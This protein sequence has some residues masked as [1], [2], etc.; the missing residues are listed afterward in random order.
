MPFR[1][2]RLP[3]CVF[4]LSL[5][6]LALTPA[7]PPARAG[8]LLALSPDDL[9]RRA[10]LVVLGTVTSRRPHPL[11]GVP[12]TDVTLAV[13][14][15][16]AGP[17]AREVTFSVLGGNAS[18]LRLEVDGEPGFREG[19]QA[20]VFL[21]RNPA[22]ARTWVLGGVQ[23]KY[24]VRSGRLEA[25]GLP[26]GEFAAR[27]RARL[28]GAPEPLSTALRP[29]ASGAAPAAAAAAA[30]PPAGGPRVL[31]VSPAVVGS[32]ADDT[33]RLTVRGQGFGAA[34]GR[35]R[36]MDWFARQDGRVV[37]WSDTQIVAVPPAPDVR[38]QVELTSGPVEVVGAAGGSSLDQEGGLPGAGPSWLEVVYNYPLHRW[39]GPGREVHFRVNPAGLPG[40]CGEAAVRSAFARWGA[41]E[42][43][44]LRFV[45]DGPTDRRPCELDGVNAVGVLS[46]WPYSRT[47]LAVTL[48]WATLEGDS[49]AL[50]ECDTAI[51][52]DGFRWSCEGQPDRAGADLETLMLHEAGHWLRLRHVNTDREILRLASWVG[53]RRPELGPGDRA[54]A[55]HVYPAYGAV[56]VVRDGGA[57]CP[58]GDAD[59]VV[60]RVRA[61]DR[62]G[63]ARAG[64]PAESV[65]VEVQA[66]PGA[67]GRAALPGAGSA[68]RACAEAPTDTAGET[69]VALRSLW[70]PGPWRLGRVRAGGHELG[71]LPALAAASLD[72]SGDGRVGVEDLELA[73]GRGAL[74]APGRPPGGPGAAWL[75]GAAG[76][77]DTALVRAHL[78]HTLAALSGNPAGRPGGGLALS[79]TPFKETCCITLAGAAGERVEVE[80]LD[81]TGARVRCVW[82]G[83][84][85]GPARSWS[86][87][88]TTDAGRAVPSGIYLVR[89]RAAGWTLTRKAV[90][91]R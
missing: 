46:P 34:P 54:G 50:E 59:S 58:A 91:M 18:G 38:L 47:W 71:A 25:T 55:S 78:G 28:A 35:V 32:A 13:S 69:W 89:V 88:G 9:A 5:P 27:L 15:T 73:R 67:P 11:G 17:A 79:P 60:L 87:D 90:R 51:N 80:V 39:R 21:E 41:V 57:L 82:A 70:G 10:D 86:W 68:G 6:A 31:G 85:E 14:E 30:E 2:P 29:R 48:P 8:A 37:S 33:L 12:A 83:A 61:C 26:V 36:F 64:V 53:T 24:G 49:G 75:C 4:V 20:L 77:P 81:V 84:V 3:A 16:L 76:L 42:G 66:D 40:G 65:W 23:G 7:P 44:R 43:A 62:E 22:S 19:E 45:D 1:F 72:L 52:V 56:E 74:A 63:R